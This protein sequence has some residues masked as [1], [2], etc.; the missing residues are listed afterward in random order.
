MQT[1]KCS[2]NTKNVSGLLK[3]YLKSHKVH[4]NFAWMFALHQNVRKGKQDNAKLSYIG[5]YT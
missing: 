5:S 1:E 2:E 4:L 3:Q